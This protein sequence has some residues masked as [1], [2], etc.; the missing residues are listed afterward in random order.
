ML[1]TQ[2]KRLACVLQA[3]VILAS[4]KVTASGISRGAERE[5]FVTVA[6][7]QLQYEQLGSLAPSR[8]HADESYVAKT[9]SLRA[10]CIN[11]NLLM[12]MRK[13]RM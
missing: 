10:S 2:L 1:Q 9:I 5:L 6:P 12:Q 11:L 3:V 4:T 8:V 13:A 7:G